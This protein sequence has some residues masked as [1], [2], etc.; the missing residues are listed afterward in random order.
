MA[1]EIRSDKIFYDRLVF[2]KANNFSIA[3]ATRER[4]LFV[5]GLSSKSYLEENKKTTSFFKAY[6]ISQIGSKRLA[7]IS[8][9]MN[10][11]FDKKIKNKSPLTS[12]DIIK[13]RLAIQDVNIADIQDL[14]DQA[15]AKEPIEGLNLEL[16]KKLQ[17]ADT[18]EDLDQITFDH[19]YKFLGS[20]LSTKVTYKKIS[21]EI[22]GKPTQVLAR[23]VY[24]YVLSIMERLQLCEDNGQ[25]SRKGFYEKLAKVIANRLMTVG[26]VIKAYNSLTGKPNYYR[27]A[28]RLVT[29]KGCISYVFIPATKDMTDLEKIRVFRGSGL[30]VA[31]IDT[32]SYYITDLEKDLGKS[33]FLSQEKYEEEI[34]KLGFVH[35]EIG[36][37]LGG[38][39]AQY[40]AAYHPTVNK[41]Y[42]FNAPGIPKHVLDK[43]NERT[44]PFK[45]HVR[46]TTQ[47][48][49][50][51]SGCY[52][53][54]Y[55]APDNVIIHYSRFIKQVKSKIHPHSIVF[56]RFKGK[57]AVCTGDITKDFNNYERSYV[58]KTRIIL[59]TFLLAPIF[60]LIRLVVRAIFSSNAQRMQ[61]LYIEHFKNNK[62]Q[63]KFIN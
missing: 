22:S 35:T 62:W 50:D 38:C 44:D 47:D 45:I 41:V 27:V 13:I 25:Y 31:D 43:F 4:A 9:K 33:A 2:N 21:E 34:Q 12:R 48:I 3:N 7:R 24:D 59:G 15:K 28:A 16:Y 10:L 32:L 58:E 52:H 36:Y 39:I 23:F 6:L 37:S 29:A 63:Y 57:M 51:K 17:K 20:F 11:D 30:K 54:G 42:L 1:V 18:V 26:T 60:R 5:L 53:L 61:G 46:R 56:A 19:L 8:Q 14:L 55:Q 49:V 40:R